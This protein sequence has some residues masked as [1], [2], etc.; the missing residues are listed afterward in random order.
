MKHF[1]FFIKVINCED[2]Y[3]RICNA[4]TELETSLK[5]KK[6]LSLLN[7]EELKEYDTKL[8]EIDEKI[9]LF[10]RMKAT[11]ESAEKPEAPMDSILRVNGPFSIL[12]KFEEP[13][14]T[15]CALVT[16]YKSNFKIF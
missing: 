13:A 11:Y 6:E 1:I 12:V 3:N 15:H 16:K 10:H 14:T 7:T 2:R 4:L 8:S 9:Q 5:T